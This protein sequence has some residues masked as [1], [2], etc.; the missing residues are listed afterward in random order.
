MHYL[1]RTSVDPP[2]C[3]DL[4]DKKSAWEDCCC[5]Q[6]CPKGRCP[7]NIRRKS[8]ISEVLRGL[9]I[10]RCAYCETALNG[11]GH[12]EHFRRKHKSHF[13]HLTFDWKNL[14]LSCEGPDTCGHFKDRK[15]A[16]AYDP[17]KL[18]KPDQHDPECFLFFHSRGEVLAREGI[19]PSAKVRANETIRV[20]GLNDP[21]LQDRRRKAIAGYFAAHN[22]LDEL[23]ELPTEERILYV[24]HELLAAESR[25]FRTAIHHFLKKYL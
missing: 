5:E 10:D 20:F 15:H 12:I 23:M 9:Q 3:L 24:E 8:Q 21:S 13:P 2:P 14:F 16:P 18:I 17:D 6:G 25:P 1:D 7:E 11:H 4:F 19:D 22:L